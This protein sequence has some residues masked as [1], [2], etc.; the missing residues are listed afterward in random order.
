MNILIVD[1]TRMMRMVIRS[2]LVKNCGI[3]ESRIFE[4]EDGASAI[5]TFKRSKSTII[6]LDINMPEMSGIE[7]VKSMM[8]INPNCRIIMCTSSS[9]R[10]DVLKCIK[11][12]ARDYIVKPPTPERMLSALYR[13]APENYGSQHKGDDD[14]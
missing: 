6:L 12:G 1:D 3:S 14:S 13:V 2:I 4:A 8:E 10:T 7:V 11:A 5:R 9:D